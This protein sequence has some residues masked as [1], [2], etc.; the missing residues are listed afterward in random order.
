MSE[1]ASLL[2]LG[3]E[4]EWHE[5]N[6]DTPLI[7]AV[8]NGH[9]D[10][11]ALL[12]AYGA[13]PATRDANGN[14]IMHII[15]MRGDEGMASLFSPNAPALA[16]HTNNDGMT[17]ID[18]AVQK[19]FNSFAEHLNNLL[20]ETVRDRDEAGEEEHQPLATSLDALSVG[21]T[22]NDLEKDLDEEH[23]N[24]QVSFTTQFGDSEVQA[25]SEADEEIHCFRTNDSDGEHNCYNPNVCKDCTSTN[26]MAQ[27]LKQL[28]Q[29]T[30]LAEQQRSELYE[31]KCVVSELMQEHSILKNKLCVY[32]GD[33]DSSFAQK[34]LA[35][36]VALEEEVKRALCRI[37][38]AKKLAASNL[39]EERV[40]VICKES[41]KCVLLMNCR[42]LC[43]CKECGHHN[44]LVQC[45]LCR[46][47][48][49]E[50][51]NVFA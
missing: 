51:I 37:E 20:Y 45:P 18:I 2:D 43:V 24:N 49:T 6:D 35:E 15:S 13:D 22:S 23:Q 25:K 39:Q 8:R 33:D 19:G 26:G 11:A 3:A 14:T 27:T 5:P 16:L 7:A 10:V 42:H 31:A 28:L 32:Q 34:S 50:R 48:I 12:L 41:P 21:D 17:A 29:I 30:H 46:E 44:S 40:C 9:Q 38:T 1:C 36:L 47:T 4:L